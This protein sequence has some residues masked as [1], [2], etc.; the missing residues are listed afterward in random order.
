MI[1]PKIRDK[2]F[3]T[4]HRGGVLTDSHHRLLAI[5]AAQCANH[6]LHY[7]ENIRPDDERP[8]R[9]V[10]ATNAWACSEI[11]M[12]QARDAAGKSQDAAREVKML[13]EAANLAALSAG[14][15]AAVAHVA[16]HELG[17]AAYAIRAVMS[18][19]PEGKKEAARQRECQWQLDRL[20][21]EIRELVIDDE[22][23]RN[24]ICWFVFS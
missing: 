3:I 4:I 7:F 8:R 22:C 23:L 9:A 1:L 6:V 14:Q 12:M 18:A 13:S 11:K 16:A 17:A 19:S 5:W 2:R 15:A 21:D 24:D 20:P 10:E